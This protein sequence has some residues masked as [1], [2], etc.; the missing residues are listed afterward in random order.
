VYSII[1]GKDLKDG[2]TTDYPDGFEPKKDFKSLRV[3]YLKRT[4]KKILR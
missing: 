4:L 1:T 3:A 2:T